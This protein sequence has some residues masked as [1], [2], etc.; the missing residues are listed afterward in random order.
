MKSVMNT[1]ERQWSGDRMR[2]GC[3]TEA[4]ADS[5]HTGHWRLGLTIVLLWPRQWGILHIKLPSAPVLNN[6]FL[7]V[8]ALRSA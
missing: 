3:R 2:T 5:K 1:D 4:A 7:C 6:V 8:C